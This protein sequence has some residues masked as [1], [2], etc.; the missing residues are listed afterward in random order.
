MCG[1]HRGM[2]RWRGGW[3]QDRDDQEEHRS[4]WARHPFRSSGNRAFD[5]YKAETLKRLAEEQ[6]EFLA[7]LT[8]LRQARDREEF[9]RFMADRRSPD[10]NPPQPQGA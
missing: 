10:R 5:E 7:F 2:R 1:M 3:A 6:R 4:W 9:D 8:R